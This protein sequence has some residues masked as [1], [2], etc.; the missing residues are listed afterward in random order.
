MRSWKVAKHPQGAPS[1]TNRS[2]CHSPPVL[3]PAER[4]A[5]QSTLAPR[6]PPITPH[7]LHPRAHNPPVFTPFRP[8][9]CRFS[10]PV[11][12]T[13]YTP[14]TTNCCTRVRAQRGAR[15]REIE[16]RIARHSTYT[17]SQHQGATHV[18]PVA[19][20]TI[21]HN[22][23]HH[24]THLRPARRPLPHTRAQ[25]RTQLHRSAPAI[26]PHHPRASARQVREQRLQHHHRCHHPRAPPPPR[27]DGPAPHLLAHRTQR[28]P[29]RT[30]P[31]RSHHDLQRTP[32]LGQHPPHRRDAHDPAPPPRLLPPA[33]AP[34]TPKRPTQKRQNR[35]LIVYGFGLEVERKRIELSTSSLRTTRST[36]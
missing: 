24:H 5:P 18:Q 9:F 6:S 22:R 21:C 29:P 26:R 30:L 35:R 12:T 11:L 25:Q 31:R 32:R 10:S 23:A 7:Q 1:S 15:G 28:R 13:T 36:S 17:A 8:D 19:S 4:F 16:G 33:R 2:S 34:T 3:R 14:H 27:H 20:I